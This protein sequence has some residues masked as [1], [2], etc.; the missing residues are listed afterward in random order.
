MGLVLANRLRSPVLQLLRFR[1]SPAAPSRRD[2]LSA[3]EW[4]IGSTLAIGKFWSVPTSPVE[5]DEGE[6]VGFRAEVNSMAFL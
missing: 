4:E 6:D 3:L 5:V 2:W 1:S